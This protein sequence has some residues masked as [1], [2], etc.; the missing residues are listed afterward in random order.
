[1][2]EPNERLQRSKTTE[3]LSYPKSTVTSLTMTFLSQLLD[4]NECFPASDCMHK[5]KNFDGGY[6]CSCNDFFKVDPVNSKNCI[7]TYIS[8][9][10][11]FE[12]INFLLE[13]II[14]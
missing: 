3:T 5:C 8:I 4:I 6:N 9:D 14:K 10:I 12:L 11:V 2:K 7:R 13:I 1:M